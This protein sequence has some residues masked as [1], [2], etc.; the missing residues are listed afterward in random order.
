MT[1]YGMLAANRRVVPF[2]PE[3]VAR[4]PPRHALTKLAVNAPENGAKTEQFF[5][6]FWKG[7]H[8]QLG[9]VAQRDRVLA[10]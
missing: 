6:T 10:S 5:R 7:L 4:F 8:H 3:P 1:D 9:P 2:G